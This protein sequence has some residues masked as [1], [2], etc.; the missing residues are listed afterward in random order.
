MELHASSYS[1]GA[2]QYLLTYN[3][4]SLYQKNID[5]EGDGGEIASQGYDIYILQPMAVEDKLFGEMVMRY[6]D[7]DTV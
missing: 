3:N 6:C 2:W 7:L 4:R 5:G 1:F